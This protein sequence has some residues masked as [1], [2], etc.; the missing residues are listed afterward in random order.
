M[1]PAL[2]TDISL[3][4]TSW[5]TAAASALVAAAAIAPVFNGLKKPSYS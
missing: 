5:I 3:V 4:L 1:L 2:A